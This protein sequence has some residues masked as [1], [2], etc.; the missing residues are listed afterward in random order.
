MDYRIRKYENK[1]AQGVRDVCVGV[2]D[3]MWQ[4]KKMFRKA[5]LTCFADYYIECEPENIFVLADSDDHVAGY[6]LC[7][8]DYQKYANDF[9]KKYL[10]K[11][12]NP[13]ARMMGKATVN[14]LASFAE[15]YPAHLH[16]DMYPEAQGHGFGRALID[17]LKKHL[18][19]I[20]V[21]GLMLDVAA[22]NKG[23]IRFYEKCGFTLLN[24]GEQEILMGIKL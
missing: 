11:T 13:V 10:K 7:A 1:D 6:V 4:E 12:L 21:R 23:A 20:G 16:I 19:E 22:D 18:T 15:E 14:A 9:N 17:T 24:K 8:A 3:Q 2:A 5:L